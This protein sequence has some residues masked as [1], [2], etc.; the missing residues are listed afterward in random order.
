MLTTTLIRKEE[1][2]RLNFAKLD[3][4]AHDF[5]KSRR[6]WSLEKALALG[7]AYHGKVHIVFQASNG[8]TMEV[9]TT[10]WAV[11]DSHISLKGGVA[12][13]IRAI[14]EVYF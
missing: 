4:L 5:D 3:V 13:P 12:I 10:I 6:L 9:D 14:R 8:E 2:S 11:T 7:N 1:I